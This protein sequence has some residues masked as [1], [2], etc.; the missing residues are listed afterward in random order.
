MT[1]ETFVY[2]ALVALALAVLI[3][4]LVAG[5]QVVDRGLN[6]HWRDVDRMVHL[7]P[8]E[9]R[10]ISREID[11]DDPEYNAVTDF[12]YARARGKHD[13]QNERIAT[14]HDIGKWQL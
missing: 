3:V 9:V 2:A 8:E 7:T 6:K 11:P 10:A 14:I 1:P 12:D 5:A 13:E 4:F